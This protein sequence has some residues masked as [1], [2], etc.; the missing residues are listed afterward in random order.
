MNDLSHPKADIYRTITDS[1]IEAIKSGAGTFTMPWHGGSA[2]IAKPEN[3]LTRMEYHGVNVLML[4]ARAYSDGYQSGYWASYRQWQRL[5]A[6]VEKGEQATPIVF[7][8]QIENERSDKE[9]PSTRLFARSSFVFN[10]AQVRGWTPPEDRFPKGGTEIAEQVARFIAGTK[11]DILW[12]GTSAH[13]H[14]PTDRIHMPDRDRFRDTVSGSA[15]YGLHSTLLHEFVHWSGAKHR[16]ARFE[17]GLHRDEV[18]FEEL[19]AEIGA[20]F[21]CA[22]L[23]VS[24]SPRLDHAAYVA[25]WLAALEGDSKVIFRAARFA[26]QAVQYLHGLAS[27]DP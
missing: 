18:P 13:Y 17:G 24:V 10:A 4:W 7:Y 1:I 14:I 8:K 16:L 9:E 2:A 21:L 6:Q 25:H 15:E 12:G 19:I 27:A 11:A 5:G 23:G 20:A 26:T 22:D 3:A